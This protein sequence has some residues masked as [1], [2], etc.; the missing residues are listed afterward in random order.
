MVFKSV[1]HGKPVRERLGSRYPFR[2]AAL[3]LKMKENKERLRSVNV[4]D[5]LREIRPE[6]E[7]EARNRQNFAKAVD[8]WNS[9][10]K[11]KMKKIEV[12]NGKRVVVEQDL[13]SL[14]PAVL[15]REKWLKNLE[16]HKVDVQHLWQRLKSREFSSYPEIREILNSPE[17][18]VAATKYEAMVDRSIGAEKTV[19]AR[20]HG[21]LEKEKRGVLDDLSELERVVG[22]KKKSG[23]QAG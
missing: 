3:R 4:I 20:Y 14:E 15:E 1:K 10:Q 13:E 6:F 8:A 12:K 9:G 7:R 2:L 17:M 23:K 11:I 16:R 19:L 22:E 21:V 18:R 5:A